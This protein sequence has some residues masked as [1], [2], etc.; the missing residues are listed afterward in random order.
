MVGYMFIRCFYMTKKIISILMSAVFILYSGNS[1]AVSA[2]EHSFISPEDIA[3]MSDVQPAFPSEMRAVSVTPSVDFLGGK[4]DGTGYSETEV[5]GEINTLLD[6]IASL[7]MNTV[8]LNTS[9]SSEQIFYDEDLNSGMSRSITDYFS[10]T[11]LSRG[12]YLYL[13][14]DIGNALDRFGD[15]SLNDKI[16]R[17]AVLM[18]NITI[19]YSPD[20]II[21]DGYYEENSA[22][23]FAEYMQN[24]SGIGYEQ[25][26]YEKNRRNQFWRDKLL[27]II[28]RV[29]LRRKKTAAGTRPAAVWLFEYY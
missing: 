24:G 11:A 19:K 6:N 21:L 9:L 23:A 15:A 4:S 20:G 22:G 8:I 14:L 17:L 2:E 16:D 3:G 12:F 26:L 29:I 5:L 27:P 13:D 10:E 7:S 28:C 18:R 25:W 1:F